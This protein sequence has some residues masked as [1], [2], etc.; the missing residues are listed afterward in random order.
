MPRHARIRIEG[1]PLH[2]TQRG[3]NREDCFFVESDRRLYLGLLEELARKYGCAVHAYALMT[4]HVHLLLTPQRAEGASALMKNLGQRY[5]QYI[6]RSRGRIGTLWAGRFQSCLVDT[7]DYL[8]RCHCYVEMNPVRAGIVRHPAEYPWSSFQ[9]NAYGEPSTILTAHP[10]VEALAGGGLTRFEAYHQL[11]DAGL[12]EA[13]LSEIRAATQGGFA[14]GSA[15]FVA[16]VAR[17]LG[18]RA[19]RVRRWIPRAS[20]GAG[21]AAAG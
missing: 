11:L 2:L 6:N 4:N 9:A 16:D 18:M 19:K 5:V 10:Q 8:L 3:I 15:Q 7:D 21:E 14:L 20:T 1:L 13:E 12:S 17:R